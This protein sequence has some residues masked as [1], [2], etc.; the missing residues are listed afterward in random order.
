M[1]GAHIQVSD[2]RSSSPFVD[3]KTPTAS[4]DTEAH[5]A[6]PKTGNALRAFHHPKATSVDEVIASISHEGARVTL[7]NYRDLL[8]KQGSEDQAY[9]KLNRL[10]EFTKN[11]N[12]S[13]PWDNAKDPQS[14]QQDR[15]HKMLTSGA[16]PQECAP[17]LDTDLQK[18]DRYR[19]E[20]LAIGEQLQNIKDN[21]KQNYQ[22]AQEKYAQEKQ[23]K[24]YER[25]MSYVTGARNP[26]ERAI[27]IKGLRFAAENA[28]DPSH[29]ENAARAVAE[30]DRPLNEAMAARGP[31]STYF[32]KT[33]VAQRLAQ[34][35]ANVEAA[36][37][38]QD[39]SPEYKALKQAAPIAVER[40]LMPSL[41]EMETQ[42]NQA[43]KRAQ[44]AHN[45]VAGY[46]ES[47]NNL[48]SESQ[49]GNTEFGDRKSYSEAWQK[50]SKAEAVCRVVANE[51]KRLVKII[52]KLKAQGGG[53]SNTNNHDLIREYNEI[54]HDRKSLNETSSRLIQTA[55]QDKSLIDKSAVATKNLQLQQDKDFDTV[56]AIYKEFSAA[57]G[58]PEK[59]ALIDQKLEAAKKA[60][61]SFDK[62]IKAATV[63][64]LD[65]NWV[66][67][68]NV[69]RFKEELSEHSIAIAP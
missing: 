29:R 44:S 36:R 24:D 59:V 27:A 11:K 9:A 69:G 68:E 39:S 48:K 58:D 63:K 30:I 16:I 45:K 5:A 49:A 3:R 15:V 23:Q 19:F 28:K 13:F 22:A 61:V 43:Q 41:E 65:E 51:E 53:A 14:V 18:L 7:E 31:Q 62:W 1:S 2:K 35:P 10:L 66:V 40:N 25:S 57:K 50:F 20:Q 26:A 60:G 67:R 37:Y 12:G 34:N 38:Y 56:R 32:V 17:R 47:K 33:E 55:A 42:R 64:A 4:P 54:I 46:Q 6:A 8:L 21:R 52:D